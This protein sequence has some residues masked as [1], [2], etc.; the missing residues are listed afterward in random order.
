MFSA[1]QKTHI[2]FLSWLLLTAFVVHLSFASI[3]LDCVRMINFNPS[4][5]EFRLQSK[6]YNLVEMLW[7]K[8]ELDKF[9]L[10]A[11]FSPL[12]SESDSYR[13]AFCINVLKICIRNFNFY[14]FQYSKWGVPCSVKL[15]SFRQVMVR[16]SVC[17]SFS[18]VEIFVREDSSFCLSV[19]EWKSLF[20][21]N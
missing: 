3:L 9:Y 12:S 14:C 16:F 10:S 6:N 2:M 21:F 4:D 1:S 13:W 8:K 5:Q 20:A 17:S 19:K 11:T 18:V 7:K 15:A